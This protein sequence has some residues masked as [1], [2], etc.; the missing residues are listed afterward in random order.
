MAMLQNQAKNVTCQ[1]VNFTCPGSG[2]PPFQISVV[3]RCHRSLA[4][5]TSVSVT[6]MNCR[7]ATKPKA[8][9]TSTIQGAAMLA[10]L[11]TVS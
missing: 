2:S 8:R 3:A 1:K 5:R 6:T 7:K 4:E 11:E 9:K 10:N